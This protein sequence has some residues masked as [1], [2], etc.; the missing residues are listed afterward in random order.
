VILP[1][2]GEVGVEEVSL[3][4]SPEVLGDVEAALLVAVQEA[5]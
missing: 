5:A 4:R 1:K 3:P 2:R